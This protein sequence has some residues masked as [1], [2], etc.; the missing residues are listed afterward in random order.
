MIILS[1]VYVYHRYDVYSI[2]REMTL[3]LGMTKKY[4]PLRNLEAIKHNIIIIQR[5]ALVADRLII[6]SVEINIKIIGI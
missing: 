4:F 2:N 6:L 5:F 3:A 1:F